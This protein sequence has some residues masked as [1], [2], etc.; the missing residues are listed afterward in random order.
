MSKEQPTPQEIAAA[1]AQLKAIYDDKVATINGRD[2]GLTVT[3]HA[4]RVKVF[5]FFSKVQGQLQTHDFSFLDT[6]EWKDV[7]RTI[8]NIVMFDGVLLNK[9]PTH[10]EEYPEDYLTFVPTMLGVI[11]YPFMRGKNT[12]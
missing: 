1:Q 6:A 5:A 2:Y 10:W 8:G 9:R 12:A 11:S 7:E 4:Q 3:S